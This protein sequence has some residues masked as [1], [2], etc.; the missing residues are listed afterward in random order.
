MLYYTD[1]TLGV[2]HPN[3]V[4]V[5]IGMSYSDWDNFRKSELF[6]NLLSFLDEQCKHP[7]SLLSGGNDEIIKE[8]RAGLREIFFKQ[9]I[10]LYE[11]SKN[12]KTE[13]LILLSDAMKDLI[14][15]MK[16]L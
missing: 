1:S 14:I 16:E 10:T 9:I 8:S 4:K 3:K 11:K 12:A 2:M 15:A 5:S 13:E 6:N 7:T